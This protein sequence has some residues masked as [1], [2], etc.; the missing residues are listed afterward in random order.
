[1]TTNSPTPPFKTV[2]VD[3]RVGDW[4]ITLDAV[5]DPL[6]LARVLEKLS[7]PAIEVLAVNYLRINDAA[8]IT[9]QMRGTK[10]WLQLLTRKLGKLVAVR[11]VRLHGSEDIIGKPR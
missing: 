5:D 6:A 7:V 1:M 8:T 10:A 9:V 4:F 3:D 11:N 2:H